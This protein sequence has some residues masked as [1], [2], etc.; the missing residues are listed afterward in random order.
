MQIAF[1]GRDHLR[2]SGTLGL[3]HHVRIPRTC[4]IQRTRTIRM[5]SEKLTLVYP[6][7]K[8]QAGNRCGCAAEGLKTF[9][10]STLRF[11]RTM[12]LVNDVVEIFT[13]AHLYMLPVDVFFS[14]QTQRAVTG[15][16]AIKR[17]FFR[18]SPSMCVDGRRSQ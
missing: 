7:G 3:D 17:Y 1:L 6:V 9:H 18:Q 8:L 10:G 13:T 15:D 4:K 14:K 5:Q 12:V 16:M 2:C 11:D